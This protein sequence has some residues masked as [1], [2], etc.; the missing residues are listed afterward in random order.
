M[1]ALTTIA[2]ILVLL[3]IAT[4]LAILRDVVRHPQPMQIMNATWPINGLFAP[5]FGWWI[6][7]KLGRPDAEAG[8]IS[9]N[10]FPRAYSWASLIVPVAVYSAT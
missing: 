1:G 9:I 3:G 2:W 7:K 5:V 8:A 10:R 4:G 6:Y